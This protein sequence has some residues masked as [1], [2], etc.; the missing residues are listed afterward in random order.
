MKPRCTACEVY[1]LLL[2][3]WALGNCSGNML[4]LVV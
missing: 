4:M 1:E 2:I 3:I